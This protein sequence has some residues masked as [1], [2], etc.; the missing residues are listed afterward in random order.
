MHA[1]FAPATA[2][3][4]VIQ[5]QGSAEVAVGSTSSFE[6]QIADTQKLARRFDGSEDVTAFLSG[7]ALT[8]EH[9]SSLPSLMILVGLHTFGCL[10]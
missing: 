9:G 5:G 2:A 6:L 1:A 4:C 7:A 10:K 8:T 3:D